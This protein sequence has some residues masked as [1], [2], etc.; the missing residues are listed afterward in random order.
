MFGTSRW[1]YATQTTPICTLQIDC[2]GPYIPFHIDMFSKYISSLVKGQLK[3]HC[4]APVGSD[5][6]G[7]RY[8][9]PGIPTSQTE[10]NSLVCFAGIE[11]FTPFCFGQVLMQLLSVRPIRGRNHEKTTTLEIPKSRNAFATSPTWQRSDPIYQWQLMQFMQLMQLAFYFV[12]Q[13]L[14]VSDIGT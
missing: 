1:F 7:W 2:C 10:Q 4:R 3:Y 5:D 14:V 9:S 13:V 12:G 8:T 11:L 6:R